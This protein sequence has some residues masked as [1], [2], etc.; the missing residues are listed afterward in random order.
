MERRTCHG[1][2]LREHNSFLAMREIQPLGLDTLIKWL[3]SELA[4]ISKITPIGS[5]ENRLLSS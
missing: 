4:D 3:A 5:Q 1:K 2:S